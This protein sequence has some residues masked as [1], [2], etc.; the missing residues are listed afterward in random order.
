MILIGMFDSPFVRRVAVSMNLLQMP[1]EHR[2]WSVGKDFE[3]IRQ[4]NPLGRVPALVLTDG[5]TLI[6]SAT[7]LDFLDETAGL[8]RALLPRSG[9]PRREALR[10]IA[11]AVGG[12]EKGVLQVYETA[13]RPPEKRYRPWVERCHTQTHAALAELDRICQVRGGEWLIGNRITQADITASCAYSFLSDAL[14]INRD[15]VVYPAL[16]AL[17]ARCEALPEFR[18]V[19]AAWFAPG[20]P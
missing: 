5:D 13:F 16:G 2:N 6:E 9:E 11:I 4:F 3:L 10:I 19:K 14:D 15:E 1:F 7:I 12:A 8:E 17:A 18:S 20:D